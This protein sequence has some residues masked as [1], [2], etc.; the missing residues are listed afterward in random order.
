MSALTDFSIKLINETIALTAGLPLN[1]PQHH[2]FEDPASL[3]RGD[4]AWMMMSTILGLFLAP[5]LANYY[6]TTSS[7]STMNFYLV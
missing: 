6:G 2:F 1:L 7:F 4:T 5:A 3:D